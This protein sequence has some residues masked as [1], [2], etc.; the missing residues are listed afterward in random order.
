MK[1]EDL[2]Y[3]KLQAQKIEH[4]NQ[5]KGHMQVTLFWFLSFSLFW[6]FVLQNVS[7]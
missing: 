4:V 6:N 7:F 5:K 1:Y 2:H 3:Y